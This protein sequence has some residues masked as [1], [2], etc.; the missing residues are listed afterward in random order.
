M[1]RL[2]DKGCR[3]KLLVDTDKLKLNIDLELNWKSSPE[4]WQ[5]QSRYWAKLDI[6][7]DLDWRS[8]FKRVIEPDKLKLDIDIELDWRFISNCVIELEYWLDIG[9]EQSIFKFDSQTRLLKNWA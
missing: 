2:C 5:A 6:G 1:D 3:F 8:I 7:L 4:H 9:F